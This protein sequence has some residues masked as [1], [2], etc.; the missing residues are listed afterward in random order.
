MVKRNVTFF[1]IGCLDM[2][3]IPELILEKLDFF[4]VIYT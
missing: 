3:L 2:D 4:L 1:L